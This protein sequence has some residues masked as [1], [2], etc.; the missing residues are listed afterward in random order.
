MKEIA[1]DRE[2]VAYCGLYCG[3]C[4]A[5][6][7]GRCPGCHENVKAKWCGIRTCGMEHGYATC[8]DCAEFAD[9]AD[10][11]KFNNVIGK[12]FGFVFNSDRHACVLKA[13][14]LGLEAYAGFMAER[15]RQS[16][17]RRGGG[18]GPQMP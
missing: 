18:A 3:A 6:L 12:L 1:V 16:L 7:K 11:R 2:L 13:R 8:A 15:G 5:Y 17:P 14:E 4:R 9:P 10:C